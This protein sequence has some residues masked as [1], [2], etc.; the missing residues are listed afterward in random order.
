MTI[1]PVHKNV[2]MHTCINT[3]K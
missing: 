2:C 3:T 1:K